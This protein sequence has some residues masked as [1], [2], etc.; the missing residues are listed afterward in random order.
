MA[1]H[2]KWAQIK[3]QKAASD[4]KR[5]QA[6]SKLSKMITI[7]ARPVRASSNRAGESAADPAVNAKLRE[8]IAKAKEANMPSDTI[9]RAIKKAT[10]PAAAGVKLESFLYEAY[11]PG[12]VALLIEGS[13]DN[14]NRS[15][16]EIKHLLSEQGAKW[17]EPGS[18]TWAFEHKEGR[19]TPLPHALVQISKENWK[20][21]DALLEALNEHDD[22]RGIYLNT[23]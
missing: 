16:N 6:F 12:G 23:K 8:I 18:V 15:A 11:G 3:H 5:G 13:T 22:T 10:T 19:W 1:G 4:A 9:E 14:R 20:K 7:A 2:S 21:L 17:A